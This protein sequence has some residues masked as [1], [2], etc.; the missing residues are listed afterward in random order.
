MA[1]WMIFHPRQSRSQNWRPFYHKLPRN[2]AQV[3]TLGTLTPSCTKFGATPSTGKWVKYVQNF[4]YLL[5]FWELTYRSDRSTWRLKLRADSR[6]DCLNCWGFVSAQLGVE[7][8]SALGSRID[9]RA[10][11]CCVGRPPSSIPLWDWLVPLSSKIS[12][13]DLEKASSFSCDTFC[14]AGDA[15]GRPCF[16]P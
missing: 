14:V 7:S 1:S 3:I 6:K 13:F 12:D 9:K 8:V 5:L 10:R 2:L 11:V 4:I 15:F 16:G